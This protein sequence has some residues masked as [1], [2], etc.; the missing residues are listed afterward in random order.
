[1]KILCISGKAQHG[2]DV[3]ASIFRDKYTE[4]GK[5]VLVIHNADLL[6]FMCKQLFGWNGEKD[7][8]GRHLLQYVGTDVVRLQEPDFWV[9]FIKKVA[10]FFNGE[11][12]YIIVPDCRFPN[13]IE[14]L[15]GGNYDVVHIR[16]VRPGFIS[17]LPPEQ[18]QHPSETALDNVK[19]D[20]LLLND[21]TISDL[22]AKI[23]AIVADMN[24]GENHTT[25]EAFNL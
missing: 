3:A 24:S 21:G 20:I 19:P 12:D 8:Y 10:D 2:K 5:K 7:D 1:M 15:R 14:C 18:Q 16:V 17:P 6:K 11:W 13:E 9:G 22:S 25:R 4:A 23:A